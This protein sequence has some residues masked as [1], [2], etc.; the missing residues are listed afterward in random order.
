MDKNIDLQ[1]FISTQ[2]HLKKQS[3]VDRMLIK[4]VN[5]AAN[6]PPG[7]PPLRFNV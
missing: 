5:R 1:G 6:R 7:L 3:F 2:M 4:V